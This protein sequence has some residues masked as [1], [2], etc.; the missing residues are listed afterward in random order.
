MQP[1]PL[2]AFN[3]YDPRDFRAALHHKKGVMFAPST[4]ITMVGAKV[5]IPQLLA[6]LDSNPLPGS[7]AVASTAA[8]SSPSISAAAPDVSMPLHEQNSK[9]LDAIYTLNFLAK[10]GYGAEIVA[11]AGVARAISALDNFGNSEGIVGTVCELLTDLVDFGVTTDCIPPIVKA[12]EYHDDSGFVKKRAFALFNKL[13][14]SYILH[15]DDIPKIH[16]EMAYNYK[17]EREH[18]LV[19]EIKRI[20][21]VESNVTVNQTATIE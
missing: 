18:G 8:S 10:E 11:Q 1:N 7:A 20:R 4:F 16:F 3:P 2:D 5:A 13:V 12:L 19:N 6:I 17:Y 21:S 14:S 15:Q 9:L